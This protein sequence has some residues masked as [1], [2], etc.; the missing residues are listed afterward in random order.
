[1][2]PYGSIGCHPSHGLDSVVDQSSTV[3]FTNVD[4]IYI[5]ITKFYASLNAVEFDIHQTFYDHD[6][7]SKSDSVNLNHPLLEHNITFT[8][9]LE[10][11]RV[12]SIVDGVATPRI[13][14]DTSTSTAA[15][16]Y[17]IGAS[18]GGGGGGGGAGAGGVV[19]AGSSSVAGG[20]FDD[21]DDHTL[22][23]GGS[24]PLH[25]TTSNSIY[26]AH[27]SR[28]N[29]I[30]GAGTN[31]VGGS[32]SR[33]ASFVS[34]SRSSNLD[35]DQDVLTVAPGSGGGGGIL[36]PVPFHGPYAT[37]ATSSAGSHRSSG[38]SIQLCR[39]GSGGP[40][41]P[42]ASNSPPTL[43]PIPPLPPSGALV[44]HVHAQHP[45]HAQHPQQSN[46]ATSAYSRL[47]QSL[48]STPNSTRRPASPMR[49]LFC[50]NQLPSHHIDEHA[51]IG[52]GSGAGGVGG[53]GSGGVDGHQHQS[54][55]SAH[56]GLRALHQWTRNQ[57]QRTTG[58]G[59]R[60]H[61]TVASGNM[62]SSSSSS[63]GVQP[64][65]KLSTLVIVLLAFLIIVYFPILGDQSWHSTNQPTNQPTNGT[66][67]TTTKLL[68][69]Q[70][71]LAELTETLFKLRKTSI[72]LSFSNS[73]PLSLYV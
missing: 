61:T 46:L 49:P 38:T 66:D 34:H 18:G 68:V 55:S 71:L 13:I 62:A 14:G 8:T 32:F 1:M 25:K 28:T 54:H 41:L 11:D 4:P 70:H 27:H 47:V 72:R 35:S 40:L 56:K 52:G 3:A 17:G 9:A 45:K 63:G 31:S 58:S 65:M 51:G 73:I 42:S 7:R 44:H 60:S 69:S 30:G 5:F 12:S 53:G 59:S 39:C 22:V 2:L 29:G 20:G 57:R 26:R 33:H 64:L 37:Y 23:Y 50:Q 67:G 6:N 19:A 10:V 43:P 16:A 24:R 15:V 48:P 36:T 21:L